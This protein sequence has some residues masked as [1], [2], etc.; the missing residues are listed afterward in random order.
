MEQI[1][2][3]VA[4][5]LNLPEDTARQAVT[6]V[7]GQLK[8]HF[9]QPIAGQIDALM[10]GSAGLADLGNITDDLNKGGGLLNKL[11]GN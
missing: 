7:L 6:L 2:K 9:P 4:E 8:E 3:L 1:V 5:K 11:F 10:S